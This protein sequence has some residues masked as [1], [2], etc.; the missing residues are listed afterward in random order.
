M[1]EKNASV[2]PAAPI[3]F[4][5]ALNEEA[6]KRLRSIVKWSKLLTL[7]SYVS[8]ALMLL[9][10]L[11][12][13]KFLDKAAYLSGQQGMDHYNSIFYTLYGVVMLAVYFFP[14]FYLHKF[15]NKAKRAL[16]EDS[17]DL[18]AEAFAEQDIFFKILGWYMILGAFFTMI[19]VFGFTIIVFLVP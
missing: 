11:F 15:S 8:L 2:S 7:A 5:I 9:F 16:A 3:K 17:E 14:L 13:G 10:F 19:M 6:L 4:D 18:L 1:E 12:I